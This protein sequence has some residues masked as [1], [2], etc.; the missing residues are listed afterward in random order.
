[1]TTPRQSSVDSAAD[2]VRPATRV[3]A[4]VIVPFL[5]AAFVI[6]YLL[7][8]RTLELFA[9][10]VKPPLTAMLLA[11]VYL[12]GA[13][14]FVRVVTAKR[15]S[16]VALGVPPVA[17]F[18][19]LLGV[20]TVLHWDR[21]THGHVSF[22]AW[23]AL[24]FAAPVFVVAIAVSNA[25]AARG[26]VLAPEPRLPSAVRVVLGVTGL[27]ELVVAAGLF[28]LPDGVGDLWPWAVTPLT[29]RT[30][31][32]V[33]A[34]GLANVL[35]AA[36]G[37]ASRVRLQLEV[38]TVMLTLIALA[39][40]LRRG[41]FAAGPGAAYGFAALVAAELAVVVGGLLA[42]SGRGPVPARWRHAGGHQA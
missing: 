20:T 12:G 38:Q 40:V 34:L 28:A 35:V 7:P 36:D 41:D 1:M 8:T 25:R 14:F 3:L 10:G 24:Y 4:L 29:A 26:A 21:F 32:A 16:E 23:A 22:V 17:L 9:W 11:A 30:L 27:T 15:W 19:S 33:Y 39:V 2:R 6:C 42:L 31:A 18:A 37:R 13:F 5:L